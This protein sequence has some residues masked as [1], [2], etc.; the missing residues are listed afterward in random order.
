[1][2]HE[3]QRWLAVTAALNRVNLTC[4]NSGSDSTAPFNVTAGTVADAVIVP[5]FDDE[6]TPCVA[7][8]AV[9]RDLMVAAPDTTRSLRV[10]AGVSDRA[11]SSTTR[12]LVGGI[13]CLLNL[14]V[15]L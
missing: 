3:A 4:G 9:F 14:D 1:M 5:A 7:F 6:V 13:L 8:A 15:F 11:S 2:A 10:A 12:G